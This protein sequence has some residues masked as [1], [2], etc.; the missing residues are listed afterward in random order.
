MSQDVEKIAEREKTFIASQKEQWTDRRG[1]GNG[2]CAEEVIS[3][4][5]HYGSGINVVQIVTD[6]KR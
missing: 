6:E 4:E 1:R 5:A 3:C 2:G